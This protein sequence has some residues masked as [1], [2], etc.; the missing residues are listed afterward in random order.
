MVNRNDATVPLV[1]VGGRTVWRD[2][3]ATPRLGTERTGVFL[4]AGERA[5]AYRPE[6]APDR[7]AVS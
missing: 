4:R 7:A 5:P 2:G 6:A 3:A 1:M